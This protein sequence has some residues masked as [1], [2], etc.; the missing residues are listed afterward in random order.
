MYIHNI[1]GALSLSLSLPLCRSIHDQCAR[2]SIPQALIPLEDV[3]ELLIKFK[4]RPSTDDEYLST[5]RDEFLKQTLR[6]V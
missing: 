1:H 5:V 2:A 3:A 4:G 6:P